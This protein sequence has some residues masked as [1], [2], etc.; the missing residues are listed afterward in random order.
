MF[1]ILDIKNQIEHKDGDI[2]NLNSLKVYSKVKPDFIFH[3][4]AQAPIS[5][6]L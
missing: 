4:A 1:D 3:L 6:V 5:K 2:R